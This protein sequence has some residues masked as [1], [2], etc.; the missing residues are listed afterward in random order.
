[1]Q[2]EDYKVISEDS[3]NLEP[4]GYKSQFLKVETMEQFS[5]HMVRIYCK[6]EEKYKIEKLKTFKNLYEAPLTN[7]LL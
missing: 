7:K 3:L 2:K 1:M 5:T 6:D 4:I